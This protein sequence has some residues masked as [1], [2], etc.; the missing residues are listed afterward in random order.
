MMQPYGRAPS[1]PDLEIEKLDENRE[2]HREVG[3]T[4]RDMKPDAIGDQVHADQQQETQGQH[5]DRRVTF[6]KTA[7]LAGENHHDPHRDNDGGDH[8]ADLIHHSNGRNDRIQG[9][10]DVEENDL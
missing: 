1:F 8:D 6:D 3:I 7:N 4:L 10:N 5:S 2:T 9:E